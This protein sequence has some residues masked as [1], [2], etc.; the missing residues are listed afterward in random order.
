MPSFLYTLSFSPAKPAASATH[1]LQ[2]DSVDDLDSC[3]ACYSKIECHGWSA[4]PSTLTKLLELM[5]VSNFFLQMYVMHTPI[6]SFF[7]KAITMSFA[8]RLVLSVFALRL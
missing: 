3:H 4:L 7:N 5:E 1:R 8:N 2:G 6:L